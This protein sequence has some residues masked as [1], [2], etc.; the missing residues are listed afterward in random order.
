MPTAQ[1]SAIV[2][3]HEWQY[4]PR[5]STEDVEAYHSRAEVLSEEARS[6]QPDYLADVSYGEGNDETVDIFPAG[7]GTPLHL[8]LHGGYW[9]GRDKR[10][11][12]F[13]AQPFVRSGI[14]L[15]IA[16]YSLC[17]RVELRE[18]VEQT[19]RC[20][21][22]LPSLAEKVDA[23]KTRITASGH[24]AGAHL[25]ACALATSEG[26]TP[27]GLA[28]AALISG[29]YELQPVLEIT[30]NE[31]IRLRPEQVASV[32]PLRMRPRTD[33]ALDIIVGSAESPGWIA[34]SALFAEHC[35]KAGASA[36]FHVEP[37]AN[38]FSIMERYN[39]ERE[40]L[41]ERLRKLA[42]VA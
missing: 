23:D 29:I 26:P 7:P 38:H 30:V 10:D 15:V 3:D 21:A 17:P 36:E 37:G 31:A 4:N 11:Y 2:R 34:Q 39:N 40:L 1:E 6:S 16:N 41:F 25:L 27:G 18:I 33:V 8:F 19:T 5:V 14:S 12:S 20:L 32:S 13:L 28:A 24:S 35:Q 9:R 22:A 42:L